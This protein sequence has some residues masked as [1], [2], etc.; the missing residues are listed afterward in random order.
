ME[1]K[2]NIYIHSNKFH[3]GEEVDDHESNDVMEPIEMASNRMMNGENQGNT[4]QNQ[5]SE[6]QLE[7][8]DNIFEYYQHAYDKVY[9]QTTEYDKIT[10]HSLS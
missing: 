9:H 3:N 8:H 2:Q 1:K 5:T 4:N 6:C 10:D 7:L